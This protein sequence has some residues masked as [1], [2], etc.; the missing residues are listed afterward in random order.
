MREQI[1]SQEAFRDL[2]TLLVGI[3][4][5]IGLILMTAGF[6]LAGDETTLFPSE[7]YDNGGMV[8]TGHGIGNF[9]GE[10][11]Y[12]HTW[13]L[14]WVINH[15][16]G[17]GLIGYHMGPQ[18]TIDVTVKG[19]PYEVKYSTLGADFE[20][21]SGYEMAFH[22]LLGMTVG[23]G[24]VE[25]VQQDGPQ[26]ESSG[27]FLVAPRAGLEANVTRWMRI[28]ATVSYR[29]GLGLDSNLFDSGDISGYT[30]MFNMKFGTF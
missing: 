9:A 23:G 26:D 15:K 13:Q 16:I 2:V 12:A 3:I 17:V 14:Q 6:A 30:V 5:V 25:S 4:V 22:P 1:R 10:T 11:E 21:F 29:A 18:E 27:F 28:S 24:F 19:H 7:I 20:C 8:S